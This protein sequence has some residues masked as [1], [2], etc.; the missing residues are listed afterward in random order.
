[1]PEFTYL[2]FDYGTKRIGVAVGQTLTGTATALQ[3]V[4]V[5]NGLP[6]KPV[7]QDLIQDWQPHALV[8]GLPLNM[9]ESI[10]KSAN[11]AK[12]FAKWLENTFDLP[13]HLIDERLSTRE[14]R[15]RLAQ[16]GKKTTKTQ[17]NSMAAQVILE[18]WLQQ[19][20]GM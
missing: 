17:L 20:Q 2:G 6:R 5:E 7:I 8:V 12:R 11:R 19:T 16:P 14:A 15:E 9:D 4:E 3:Q 10:S 1:M 18:T 13:V